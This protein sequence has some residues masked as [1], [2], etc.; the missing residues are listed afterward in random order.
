MNRVFTA[1]P[2]GKVR[3]DYYS[4]PCKDCGCPG[5]QVIDVS[6]E[7]RQFLLATQITIKQY[8][9]FHCMDC[10]RD[11]DPDDDRDDIGLGHCCK[12]E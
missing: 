12:V 3:F 1:S 8:H 9:C 2:E 7:Y 11:F 5:H 6:E 10:E 4:Y